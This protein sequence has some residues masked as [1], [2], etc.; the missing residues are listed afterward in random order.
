MN[1]LKQ[2]TS[3]SVR[4][5]KTTILGLAIIVAAVL[6]PLVGVESGEIVPILAGVAFILSRDNDK[7][8]DS[9]G[10]S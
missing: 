10:A 6:L 7:S 5:W 4:S 8:S 9:V 1:T 2:I 3:S